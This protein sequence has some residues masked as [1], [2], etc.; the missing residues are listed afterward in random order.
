MSDKYNEMVFCKDKYKTEDEMWDDI[1]DFLRILTKQN[2]EVE[3]Y[4]DEQGLG[5]YCVHY[6]YHDHEYGYASIEWLDCDEYIT[7][8]GSKPLNDDEE[9][10]HIDDILKEVGRIEE[11]HWPIG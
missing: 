6:N 1:R 5:I 10:D 4:C 11:V 3:F 8:E 2:M 9:S 7:K